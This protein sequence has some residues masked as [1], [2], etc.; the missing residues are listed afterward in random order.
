MKKVYNWKTAPFPLQKISKLEF[1]SLIQSYL[2]L[3]EV[4]PIPSGYYRAYI[5]GGNNCN[6]VKKILKER[7]HWCFVD[8]LDDDPH[9]VWTQ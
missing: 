1:F 8:S 6:L 9:F 2:H 7:G 4:K 5:G 3:N